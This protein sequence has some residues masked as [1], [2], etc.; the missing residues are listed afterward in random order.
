MFCTSLLQIIDNIEVKMLGK[1][2]RGLLKCHKQECKYFAS[3]SLLFST[4]IF[5]PPIATFPFFDRIKI[6]MPLLVLFII[7]TNKPAWKKYISK[8]LN[9]KASN[10]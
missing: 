8:G 3:N 5:C 10:T 6:T 7:S 1:S 4:L 9:L 2:K